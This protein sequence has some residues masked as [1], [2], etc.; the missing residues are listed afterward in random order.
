MSGR[1][2]VDWMIRAVVQTL[3]VYRME[4]MYLLSHAS[5]SGRCR[6]VPSMQALEDW[7]LNNHL[8]DRSIV[9]EET[10]P[11]LYFLKTRKM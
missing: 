3:Q 4:A 1:G 10:R 7:F 11:W 9:G 5:F 2:V 6:K 8:R